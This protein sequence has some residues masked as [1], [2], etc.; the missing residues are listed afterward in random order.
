MGSIESVPT[1]EGYVPPDE[2]FPDE[3][4]LKRLEDLL[5]EFFGRHSVGG[6]VIPY[7]YEINVDEDGTANINLEIY[8]VKYSKNSETNAPKTKT[9]S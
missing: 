4:F 8:N 7:F 6:K 2:N 3:N 1:P 9:P 5:F